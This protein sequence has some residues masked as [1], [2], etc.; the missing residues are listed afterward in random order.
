MDHDLNLEE[1]MAGGNME[2]FVAEEN[3]EEDN[4]EEV[5]VEEDDRKVKRR[6]ILKARM[7]RDEQPL[8]GL[9]LRREGFVSCVF[10]W[11]WFT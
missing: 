4:S 1:M 10:T 2:E 11:R 7:R 5:E 6:K 3:M 9:Q 8:F